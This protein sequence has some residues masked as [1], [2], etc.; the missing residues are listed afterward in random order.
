MRTCNIILI[1]QHLKKSGLLTSLGMS[2]TAYWYNLTEKLK[3]YVDGLLVSFLLGTTQRFFN[4][5]M[6]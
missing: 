5:T 4:V 1:V 3:V 6:T 2:K